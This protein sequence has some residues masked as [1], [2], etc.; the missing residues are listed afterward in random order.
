MVIPGTPPQLSVAVANPVT[1]GDVLASQLTV[2]FPGQVIKGTVSSKTV[3]VWAHVAVFPQTSVAVYT[4]VIVYLFGQVSF[5]ITSGANVTITGPPQLSDAITAVV[6]G[7]GT[8]FAH[9]TV[10]SAG[11]VINGGVSSKTVIN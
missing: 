6:L 2:T 11:Q 8:R 7:A 10:I 5:E 4:R 3:I 9:S 1:S